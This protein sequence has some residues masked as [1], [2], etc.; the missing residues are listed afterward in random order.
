MCVASTCLYALPTTS[1]HAPD[2]T[3]DGL[4]R[5]L[6]PDLD[7]G[8][9]QLLDSLWCDITLADEH[10]GGTRR[11]ASTPGDMEG[12]AGG[13]QPRSRTAIWSFVQGGTGGALPEPYKTTFN[14]PL[15]CRF[16]LKQ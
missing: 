7:Q 12:A 5:D 15:M 3:T 11:Q 10:G 8:I 4:L 14:R 9:G 2:E 16:L 13:Q 1:G 6:L